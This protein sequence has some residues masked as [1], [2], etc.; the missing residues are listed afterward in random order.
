[1]KIAKLT[2]LALAI[3]SLCGVNGARAAQADA[4][5]ADW[6]K[7]VGAAK[8]EGTTDALRQPGL[9]GAVRR[10]EQKVSGDQNHRGVQSRRGR[11]EAADVRAARG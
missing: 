6:D 4:W 9:R 11:G 1:M 8:K 7:S 3:C 5:K 10:T 2:F